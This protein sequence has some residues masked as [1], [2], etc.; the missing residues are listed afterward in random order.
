MVPSKVL[1]S[2]AEY[3][4]VVLEDR[5]IGGD[6]QFALERPVSGADFRS[7]PSYK[8]AL[9][10]LSRHRRSSPGNPR[11]GAQPN[12]VDNRAESG[13]GGS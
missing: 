2:I 10:A 4:A 8:G 7:L 5:P 11:S 3:R 9:A 12:V 1:K 6:C 13:Y